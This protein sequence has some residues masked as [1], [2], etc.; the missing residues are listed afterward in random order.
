MPELK[1]DISQMDKTRD[2]RFVVL[3]E[4]Y[5]QAILEHTGH[6]E[7]L[8]SRHRQYAIFGHL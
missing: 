7:N 3:F 1:A 5:I 8:F 2:I 4:S 6:V